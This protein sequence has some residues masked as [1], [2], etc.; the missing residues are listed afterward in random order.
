MLFSNAFMNPDQRSRSNSVF[1]SSSGGGDSNLSNPFLISPNPELSPVSGHS[2]VFQSDPS[3]QLQSIQEV[4]N[5]TADI[6]IH[7]IV[8][9]EENGVSVSGQLHLHYTGS[10]TKSPTSISIQPPQHGIVENW[11]VYEGISFENNMYILNHVESGQSIPILD[12]K[13]RLEHDQLPIRIHPAWKC[14]PDTSFLIV[15]Y[16]WNQTISGIQGTLSVTD[17]L[18]TGVQ[19]T[20]QGLWDN[21][22]LS[23]SLQ[24]IMQSDRL[25]A[26]FSV[27][28]QSEPKP[29]QL[30][31]RYEAASSVTGLVVASA[32]QIEI[33]SIHTKV[34]ST[35]IIISP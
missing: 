11:H 20:P 9:M 5:P 18:V 26:K 16:N 8:S 28:T 33:K 19:S 29:L 27:S 7:E 15:K 34:Q 23:W 31:Y 4:V 24:D 17:N 6:A 35:N 21:K 3:W 1:S 22:T 32:S 14:T 30:D 10:S 2:P 13:I 25:L 12:Y